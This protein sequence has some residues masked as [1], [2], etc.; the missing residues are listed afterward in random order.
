MTIDADQASRHSSSTRVG[1]GTSDDF[2]ILAAPSSYGLPY[3]I[4]VLCNPKT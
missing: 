4:L 3:A 2:A 1:Y